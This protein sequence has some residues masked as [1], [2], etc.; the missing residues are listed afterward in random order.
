[1]EQQVLERQVFELINEIL[2]DLDDN[3]PTTRKTSLKLL[4]S[5]D[6]AELAIDIETEFDIDLTEAE[7]QKWKTVGDVIDSVYC[8]LGTT[9]D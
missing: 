6:I 8:F 1:M 4:D 5:L 7:I 3:A 9:N 2:G